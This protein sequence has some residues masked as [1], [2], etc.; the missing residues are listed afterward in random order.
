[1]GQAGTAHGPRAVISRTVA[2][3]VACLTALVVVDWWAVHTVRGRLL[4]ARS[5]R[6][7]LLTGPTTTHAL[8]QVL[9]VV[10]VTSLLAAVAVVLAIALVRLHG[11]LGLAAVALLIG[12][13]TTAAQARRAVPPVPASGGTGRGHGQQFAQRPCDG[14]VLRRG[15][16]GARAPTR[17]V[18]RGNRRRRRLHPGHEH[19][20]H[21][22]RGARALDR[23]SNLTLQYADRLHRER[24]VHEVEHRLAETMQGDLL[25]KPAPQGIVGAARYLPSGHAGQV[26]GDWY[27]L[28]ALPDGALGVAVGDVMGHDVD[29]AA[30]GVLRGVLRSYAYAASSPSTVLDQLN[31]LDRLV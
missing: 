30:A 28:F 23:H 21:D 12:A 10:S 7:A 1:M 15:S 18:W 29:A 25:P 24:V 14:R 8:D 5:L 9:D 17:T 4:D 19:R 13:N 26:G 31:Q 20:D 27:D 2:F 16:S 22:R 6:G 3:A 11:A